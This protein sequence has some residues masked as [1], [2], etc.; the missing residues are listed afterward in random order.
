MTNTT[1]GA[2]TWT[3]TGG[4]AAGANFGPSRVYTAVFTLTANTGFNFNGLPANTLT[5][6]GATSVSH[7]AVTTGNT[8]E[9]TVVFPA[10]G[11]AGGGAG[12]GSG[13]G[14]TGGGTTQQPPQWPWQP[15]T[16]G[17]S[18]DDRG[19]G[20]SG[21]RSAIS[22]LVTPR[23][24]QEM[25]KTVQMATSL[26]QGAVANDQNFTRSN[27]DG[28]YGVRAAAWDNLDGLRFD[29]DTTDARGVQVRVTIQNPG[30]ISQDK[31]V[32]AWVSGSDVNST[33]GIFERHFSN[34][35]QVV[36]FD[37]SGGWGQTVRVAARVDLTGMDAE[38]LY[39]YSYDRAA[40]TFRLIAEPNYRIDANGFLWFNTANGGSVVISDGALERR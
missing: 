35:V 7:P 37:H 23:L 10:T 18:N 38:S 31:L 12:S 16:T 4:T 6:A 25:W 26:M 22:S 27:H 5:V 3:H 28:R 2:I 39:F 1:P 36:H 14:T 20:G 30:E 17:S 34:S 29:H 32:S 24:P 9:V 11:A 15:P 33:R 13:G 8:V 40:N 19:S 21:I